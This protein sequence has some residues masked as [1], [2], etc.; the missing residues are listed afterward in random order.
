MER[1]FIND[2]Q[3]GAWESRGTY[4]LFDGDGQFWRHSL[5]PEGAVLCA[6]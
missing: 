5:N 3:A 1:D 6:Y 2:Y 4:R